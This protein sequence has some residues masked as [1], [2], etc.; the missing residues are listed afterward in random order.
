MNQPQLKQLL[1]D[2]EQKMALKK[3]TFVA[4]VKATSAFMEPW[5]Q[6]SAVFSKNKLQICEKENLFPTLN[7][8][9]NLTQHRTL[10]PWIAKKMT[11]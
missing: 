6:T 2:L 5:D 3:L 8:C 4:F 11:T 1:Q 10:T 7:F 9:K